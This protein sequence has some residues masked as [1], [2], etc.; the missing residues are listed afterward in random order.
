MSD[1]IPGRAESSTIQV[2]AA[3]IGLLLSV[4]LE[5]VIPL[6]AVVLL[7][8]VFAAYANGLPDEIEASEGAA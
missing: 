5:T 1:G 8:V 4:V 6:T 2:R 7:V 3:L